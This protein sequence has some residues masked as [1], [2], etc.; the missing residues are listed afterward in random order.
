MRWNRTDVDAL[1]ELINSNNDL[2]TKLLGIL[3]VLDQI[4]TS[5]L[6]S[7]Q[8]LLGVSIRKR[9]SRGNLGS[10][11]VHL[12]GTCGSYDNSGIRFEPTHTAFNIAEFLHAHVGT[13]T[14][15][16]EDVADTI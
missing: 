3:D 14:A 2:D 16:G 11:T 1:R 12:E 6:E 13:E 9:L 5:L 8:I 4:L 7:N 15:F 10:T